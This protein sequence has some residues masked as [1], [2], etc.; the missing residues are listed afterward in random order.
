MTGLFAHSLQE[1]YIE[2]PKMTLSLYFAVVQYLVS[3]IF[4][5]YLF[6]ILYVSGKFVFTGNWVR[7]LNEFQIS[8]LLRSTGLLLIQDPKLIVNL[9]QL[10]LCGHI[11]FLLGSTFS[12][13]CSLGLGSFVMTVTI[14]ASCRIFPLPLEYPALYFYCLNNLLGYAYSSRF[15]LFSDN[16]QYFFSFFIIFELP[17]MSWSMQHFRLASS[18]QNM[19][20]RFFVSFLG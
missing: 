17:R 7:I 3:F 14:G 2:F 15:L 1:C 16:H 6:K 20:L 4:C 12:F 9:L 19:H 13:V 11:A 5:G 10:S 8:S 18:L